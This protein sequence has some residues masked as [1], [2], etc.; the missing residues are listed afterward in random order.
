MLEFSKKVLILSN[1]RWS[2]EGEALE[3]TNCKHSKRVISTKA[4]WVDERLSP[5]K[6]ATFGLI[7][8]EN[9]FDVTTAYEPSLTVLST[10]FTE[11]ITGYEASSEPLSISEEGKWIQITA[12]G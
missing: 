4:S 11:T 2:A 9:V 12:K 8:E 7:E 10:R 1:W 3:S 6:M 5:S